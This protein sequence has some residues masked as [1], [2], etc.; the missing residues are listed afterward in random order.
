M[1]PLLTRIENTA[2]SA[3]LRELKIQA[4]I[5]HSVLISHADLEDE[6]LRP[7]ILQH[8]PQ[9]AP[10][11]NGSAAPTD[12]QIIGAGLG[13][14]LAAVEVEKARRLLLDTVVK[15]RK[16]FLKEETIIFPIA[17]RELSHQRQDELGAEW[18]RRRGV[19]VN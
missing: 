12:H 7:V 10:A 16:H 19:S 4:S 18:A 3:D 13:E 14:V 8:L 6:L 2:S 9:P 1:Y 11:A 17:R 15:T 5:L